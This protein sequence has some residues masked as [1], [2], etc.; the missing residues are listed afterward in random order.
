[1]CQAPSW[2][3]GQSAER[4]SIALTRTEFIVDFLNNRYKIRS[5]M[6]ETNV[7][8]NKRTTRSP[9]LLISKLEN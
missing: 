7:V 4:K 2:A 1:M 8:L 9:G 5:N 3:P 6:E